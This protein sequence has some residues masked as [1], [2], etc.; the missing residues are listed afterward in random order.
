MITIFQINLSD[1]EID[2]VN[3]GEEAPR[4][5]AR[6]DAMMGYKWLEEKGILDT[7][8]QYYRP[9]L[10]VDTDDLEEAFALTNLWDQLDRVE[11][12]ERGG[13]TSVGDIAV[14]DSGRVSICDNFGWKT[15]EAA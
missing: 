15:L 7:V 11:R 2:D 10:V 14:E 3:A 5:E 9:A 6:R 8:Q 12:L 1:Q 4:W 13:S